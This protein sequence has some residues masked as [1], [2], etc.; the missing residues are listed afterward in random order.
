MTM[1]IITNE[2]AVAY[3]LC[4]RK[5]FL[6]L[7]SEDSVAPHDYVPVI[8]EQAHIARIQYLKAIDQDNTVVSSC[9]TDNVLNGTN[10]IVGVTLKFHDLEAYC[11]VLT[12]L[13]SGSSQQV[14][15]YEPTLVVGTHQITK[16]QKLE[17]SYVG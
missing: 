12:K 5:A 9:D 15:N 13:Q 17:L 7:H 2:I 8:D 16:E 4:Q 1:T 6:L 14:R 10:S 11:D 3:S